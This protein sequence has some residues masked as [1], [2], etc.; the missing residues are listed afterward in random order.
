MWAEPPGKELVRITDDWNLKSG[1]IFNS[2]QE[3]TLNPS[4]NRAK[5]NTTWIHAVKKECP[6][7]CGSTLTLILASD[8]LTNWMKHLS[9]TI[10][11]ES[12]ADGN[13]KGEQKR[14]WCMADA[15]L[16]CYMQLFCKRGWINSSALP[17]QACASAA[18][19]RK[20]KQQKRETMRWKWM[21]GTESGNN[22]WEKITEIPFSTVSSSCSFTFFFAEREIKMCKQLQLI[23]RV[24]VG[25]GMN[26]LTRNGSHLLPQ[27]IM[28]QQFWWCTRFRHQRQMVVKAA[29]VIKGGTDDIVQGK[30]W[31]CIMTSTPSLPWCQWW[32]HKG[33]SSQ[34]QQEADE[35]LTFPHH[36]RFK[37]TSSEMECMSFVILQDTSGHFVERKEQRYDPP[38]SAGAR[39]GHFNRNVG[40]NR[41]AKG[42]AIIARQ[43]F[44]TEIFPQMK[45]DVLT[46]EAFAT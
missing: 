21:G 22:E 10:W 24:F 38:S 27:H 36:L 18:H 6:C 8:S 3:W 43:G 39:S 20:Q 30:E 16:W 46:V 45:S 29:I 41:S 11:R 7:V 13:R 42:T 23:W 4:V 25:K 12:P 37:H 17:H 9:S 33:S 2:R 26:M 44:A 19:N 14:F 1:L 40:T 34:G 35:H 32:R 15:T 28:A 5:I 31:E